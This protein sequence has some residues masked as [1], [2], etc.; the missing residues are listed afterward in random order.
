CSG[1]GGHTRFARDW[2]PDLCSADL[3][4]SLEDFFRTPVARRDVLAGAAVGVVPAIVHAVFGGFT[5]QVRV[6]E[7]AVL[8]HV[9]AVQV[10]GLEIGRASCRERV[11]SVVE[12]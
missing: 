5:V 3:Y 9:L 4:W 10:R 1:R 7:E 12:A 8:G 2:S 6:V 11:A